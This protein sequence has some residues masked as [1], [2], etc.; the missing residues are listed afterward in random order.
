MARFAK[1]FEEKNVA[2]VT[3]AL[4][5]GENPNQKISGWPPLILAISWG[6][7]KLARALLDAKVKVDIVHGKEKTTPLH[8]L[9]LELRDVEL[10]K[11][12][13]SL[14]ARLDTFAGHRGYAPLHYAVLP[15][16]MRAR[17]GGSVPF[18]G[19]L[20]DH[21]ADINVRT[22]K[23]KRTPL[24]LLCQS[25]SGLMSADEAKNAMLLM[26]HGADINAVDR[27]GNTPLHLAAGSGG[28]D[29]VKALLERKAKVTLD[30]YG[31]SPLHH[32]AS[33][34]EIKDPA[35]WQ[36]LIDARCDVNQKNDEGLTPFTE[37]LRSDA[38]KAAKF[39]ASRGAKRSVLLPEG[40]DPIEYAEQSG[41]LVLA[42]YLSRTLR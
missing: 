27:E 38:V 3:T 21:G 6:D 20:L 22:A 15:A 11:Q 13:L 29:T 30:A 18:T 5:A 41:S 28:R 4:K 36:V 37:A 35:L 1:H 31:N 14:G 25:D 23:D 17:Y 34:Q 2:A 32:A 24:H 8:L 7:K 12:M 9:A 42:K 26:K 39:L 40:L 16:Y 10:G 33:D 19:L